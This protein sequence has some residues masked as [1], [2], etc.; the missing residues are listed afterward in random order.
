MVG[1]ALQT[2]SGL[3]RDTFSSIHFCD[4]IL[5]TNLTILPPLSSNVNRVI[6]SGQKY[7][8]GK[9]WISLAGVYIDTLKNAF[10]CDSIVTTN[11][12]VN[13]VIIKHFKSGNAKVIPI[14]LKE[15]GK[16]NQ[17][18]TQIISRRK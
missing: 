8:T 1:G 2:S 5:E 7:W 4:S 12:R 13:R 18:F 11:L 16:R 6:C 10:L 3:Y 9:Q 15:N 17:A 14:L